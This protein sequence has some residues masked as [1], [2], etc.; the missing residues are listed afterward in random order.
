MTRKLSLRPMATVDVVG[1]RLV[2][3]RGEMGW[4]GGHN[5]SRLAVHLGW[6]DITMPPVPLPCP[7]ASPGHTSLCLNCSIK[8]QFECMGGQ[9]QKAG[10]CR[11]CLSPPPGH[12]PSAFSGREEEGGSFI[13]FLL[14]DLTRFSKCLEVFG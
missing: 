14:K 9:G 4:G 10:A 11:T 5:S 12:P 7:S 6:G 8:E 1:G 2:V 3:S 13:Y